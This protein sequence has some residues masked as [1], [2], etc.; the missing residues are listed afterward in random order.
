MKKILFY[1]FGLIGTL[2]LLAQTCQTT[3]PPQP[4]P[5]VT[6]IGPPIPLAVPANF[7]QPRL[8]TSLKITAAGVALGRVLFYDGDLS[9]NRQIACATCHQQANA[10]TH[11]GH[12]LSHGV[13]DRL[14]RRNAPPIQNLVWAKNFFWDGGVHHLDFTPLTAL[15]D[16]AEMNSDIE[17]IRFKL[18]HSRIDY[19]GM[20][21]KAY[22]TRE[23]TS[24]RLLRALTQFMSQLV[25]ASSRYDRYS[26]GEDTTLLTKQEK[27]GLQ[28]FRSKC[29]QCHQGELFTDYSFRNNGLAATRKREELEFGMTEEQKV[30]LLATRDEGRYRVTLN[31]KDRYKFR[32]PSL[33][34]VQYTGPYMHDGRFTVLA[35]V[36]RHYATGIED[37]PT[38]D[39]RLRKGKKLGIPMTDDEQKKII[40]FLKTL[41]D[42][43]FMKDP[44]YADPRLTRYSKL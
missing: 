42:P 43:E 41:S 34:N 38:L 33:R 2:M 36:L 17:A 37:S 26:R 14:S 12:R 24:Q 28:L 32:V 10:F 11:H 35:Q 8:D 39:P 29:S 4:A 25:S 1:C 15:R 23:I 3:K 6:V 40:A 21:D 44:R 7:P 18:E 30:R 19:N 27:E 5:T 22:G 20:F 13:D 31:K 16:T 9:S